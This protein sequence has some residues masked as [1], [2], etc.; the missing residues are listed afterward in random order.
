MTNDPYLVEDGLSWRKITALS[1]A[2]VVHVGVFMFMLAPVMAPEAQD[3][4]EETVIDV[5]FLEPPPPEPEPPVVFDEPLA[6]SEPAPPPAP[7]APPSPPVSDTGATEDPSYRKLYQ[8]KY[9]P[10]AVRRRL[11]GEVMLRVL[12]GVDGSPLK[13]SIDRSSRHRELDQAAMQAVKRWKFNPEVKNGRPVEGWVLV[14][15]SFK[16]TEG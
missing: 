15:I 12:V 1:T 13:I 9:P 14:P 5:V 10:A 3:K 11:E 2:M 7:P 6:M 16:L 4:E 8:P